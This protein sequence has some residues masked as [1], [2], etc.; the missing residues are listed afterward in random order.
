AMTA[1]AVAPPWGNNDVI[2]LL[3]PHRLGHKSAEFVHD[4]GN[5]MPRGDGRRN[6]G[7]FPEVSVDELY[8][9]TAHSTR[10]YLDKHLIGL[11]VR[12]GHV[13]E[14]ESLAI[15]VHACCFHICFPSNAMGIRIQVSL[16]VDLKLPPDVQRWDVNNES[17]L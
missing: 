9:R 10:P 13:L 16:D 14:D 5:F 1:G 2:T 11:N 3:I 7:V 12:N 4:A 15:L 6:V 8:I 17:A